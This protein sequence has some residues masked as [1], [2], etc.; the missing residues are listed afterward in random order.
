MITIVVNFRILS[1]CIVAGP[2][3]NHVFSKW[4]ERKETL[5]VTIVG[6]QDIMQTIVH[7]KMTVI[8][9]KS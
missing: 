7:L 5:V 8:L 2:Y 6:S 4:D 3:T 9:L 1:K